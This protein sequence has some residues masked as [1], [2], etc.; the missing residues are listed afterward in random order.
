MCVCVCIC[1]CVCLWVRMLMHAGRHVHLCRHVFMCEYVPVCRSLSAVSIY[2]KLSLFNAHTVILIVHIFMN[3][4]KLCLNQVLCYGCVS[5]P[6]HSTKWA[7]CCRQ[8]KHRQ[9]EWAESTPAT[10]QLHC[11]PVPAASAATECRGWQTASECGEPNQSLSQADVT[12]VE[13][14]PPCRWALSDCSCYQ[15]SHTAA[16]R[17]K[18]V[19][20]FLEGVLHVQLLFF[21]QN[22]MAVLFR[23]LNNRELA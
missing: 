7:E 13:V 22:F 1:V 15:S 5:G 14:W 19:C 23:W 12:D 10:S 18:L 4:N 20:E 17:I 3:V 16:L 2:Y 21:N 11:S 9:P 8:Y 6:W